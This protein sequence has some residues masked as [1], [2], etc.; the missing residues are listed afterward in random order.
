MNKFTK[1]DK[2]TMVFDT[3]A[4]FC[5]IIDVFDNGNL[6]VSK[7]KIAVEYMNDGR[8]MDCELHPTLFRGPAEA[9]NYFMQLD[10]NRVKKTELSLIKA[11]E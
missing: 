5:T 8:R 10:R 11:E 2:L 7:G 3:S 6:V 1:E 9:A 4:G